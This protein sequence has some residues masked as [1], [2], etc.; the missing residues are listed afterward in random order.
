MR[1]LLQISSSP[2]IWK[3]PRLTEPFFEL[4][5]SEEVLATLRFNNSF[6]SLATGTAAEGEWSFKRLG[7]MKTYIT[8]REKGKDA[9]IA[10]FQNNTWSGG[11][12]LEFPDGR[13]YRANSNFWHSE[14]EFTDEEDKPLIRYI[15]IGGF[16]LHAQLELMPSAKEL[17]EMPWMVLLGWYLAVMTSREGEMVAAIF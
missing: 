12:T 10:V 7:F 15:N 2:L 17:P 11:G 4:K 14:V 16:K 3:Q 8:I 1:S 13:K 6:G 5:Y 9:N